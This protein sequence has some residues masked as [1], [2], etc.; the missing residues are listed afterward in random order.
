MI[1]DVVPDASSAPTILVVQNWFDEL[2]SRV[3][4]K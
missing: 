1:K 3:P 2:K 4:V